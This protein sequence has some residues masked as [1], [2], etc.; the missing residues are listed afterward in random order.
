[1]SLAMTTTLRPPLSAGYSGVNSVSTHATMPM[2]FCPGGLCIS[3]SSKSSLS[4]LVPGRAASR[5]APVAAATDKSA[6][7]PPLLTEAAES[8]GGARHACCV[9]ALG[10]SSFEKISLGADRSLDGC[11]AVPE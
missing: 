10:P 11:G 8:F 5:S 3:T 9:A 1:M 4:T 2:S 6:A 7:A